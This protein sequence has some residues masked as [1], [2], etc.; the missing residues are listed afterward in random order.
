MPT[1]GRVPGEGGYNSLMLTISRGEWHWRTTICY[2]NSCPNSWLHYIFSGGN[3]SYPES[4]LKRQSLVSSFNLFLELFE[5]R[6]I[7]VWDWKHC[8]FPKRSTIGGWFQ[9]REWKLGLFLEICMW[10]RKELVFESE[11]WP[12]PLKDKELPWFKSLLL[13]CEVFCLLLL[14]YFC[15]MEG[16]YQQEGL[17]H[18]YYYYHF[19]YFKDLVSWPQPIPLPLDLPWGI[20]YFWLSDLFLY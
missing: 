16:T 4:Q 12:L 17:Y 14:G 1:L 10:G 9:Y 18:G 11:A 20:C 7:P 19:Y 13:P 15:Q 5:E 3:I 2:W 6:G 8:P